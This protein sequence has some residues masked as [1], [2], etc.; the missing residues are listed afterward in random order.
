[1]LSG[2]H[3]GHGWGTRY[4]DCCKPH[5]GWDGNVGKNAQ[6]KREA[7][8]T[9][10]TC[11]NKMETIGNGYKSVC[12][13]GEA[14]VCDFQAPWAA[15]DNIAFGFAAV[16]AADGAKCGYCY[17]LTFDGGDH[18]GGGSGLNGKKMVIMVSNIGG[19]VQQGQFDIMIPGGGVGAFNGCGRQLG[20]NS[21]GSQYGG[22]LS[23][24]GGGNKG[25]LLDKCKQLSKFPKLQAGCEFLANWL[26]AADN[27]TFKYEELRECPW[28][29]EQ[30]W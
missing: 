21:M 5:C 19:D 29:L 8:T 30:K 12:D 15:T 11:D 22:Y 23:E 18:Q 10:Q 7:K 20:I 17:L 24:C 27:P 9:T 28:E 13:G 3:Q 1:V 26:N 6:D 25:C 14:G 4:W 2:G 16:P